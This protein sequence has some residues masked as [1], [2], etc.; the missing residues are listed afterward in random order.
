[1]YIYT[2]KKVI[3]RDKKLE[4]TKLSRGNTY[5]RIARIM[6]GV[7]IINEDEKCYLNFFFSFL[8]SPVN[9]AVLFV[10]VPS[11]R[12]Q[13]LNLFLALHPKLSPSPSSHLAIWSACSCGKAPVLPTSSLAFNDSLSQSVL[14]TTVKIETT[15]TT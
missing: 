5:S 10:R 9:A 3:G 6:D 2:R 11:I 13:S 4:K 15:H 7:A 12:P 1:M 8:S 14:Y